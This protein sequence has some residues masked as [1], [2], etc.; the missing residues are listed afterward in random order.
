MRSQSLENAPPK[1]ARTLVL[2]P[3]RQQV[4][5][6]INVDVGDLAAAN[7]VRRIDVSSIHHDHQASLNPSAREYNRAGGKSKAAR[8]VSE[9]NDN[10]RDRKNCRRAG[11]E[12]GS[13]VR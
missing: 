11:S 1:R 13:L 5:D 2:E 4:C 12:T 8:D 3:A 7:P 6:I 9:I 10:V